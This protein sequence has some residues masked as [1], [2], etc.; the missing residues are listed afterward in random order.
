MLEVTT[1]VWPREEHL[2][3]V[4]N[5]IGVSFSSVCFLDPS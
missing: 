4:R 5:G 3:A 2:R 1:M